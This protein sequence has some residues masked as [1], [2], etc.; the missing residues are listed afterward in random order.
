MRKPKK[1][2]RGR[3]KTLRG[4][5]VTTTVSLA[6]PT[7]LRLR[8]LAVDEKATVRDLI[9]LAVDEFMTRHKGGKA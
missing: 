8:H 9:R 4:T 1:R 7:Y 2:P 3:P 6:E 5:F